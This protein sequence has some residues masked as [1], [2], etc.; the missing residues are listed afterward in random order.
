MQRV[1]IPLSVVSP[2][3]RRKL[4][5][6]LFLLR[7]RYRCNEGS[8]MSRT[9]LHISHDYTPTR[10]DLLGTHDS[11]FLTSLPVYHGI[12]SFTRFKHVSGA[13]SNLKKAPTF[14]YMELMCKFLGCGSPSLWLFSDVH[15]ALPPV[16][17]YA[18]VGKLELSHTMAPE[19]SPR[20]RQPHGVEGLPTECD[21]N[22]SAT[23]HTS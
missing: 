14:P 4:F 10:P 18:G 5:I 13:S 9:T 2:V 12:P 3:L 19:T 15:H 16:W 8:V 20:E 1:R 23:S 11:V 6:D 22:V 21:G 7:T 17:V